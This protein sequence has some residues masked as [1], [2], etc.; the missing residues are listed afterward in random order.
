M[1]VK[2]YEKYKSTGEAPELITLTYPIKVEVANGKYEYCRYYFKDQITIPL[3]G[4]EQDSLPLKRDSV[5]LENV[6][7]YVVDGEWGHFLLSW[8]VL[9][10][11]GLSPEANLDRHKG[12]TFELS[13]EQQKTVSIDNEKTESGSPKTTQANVIRILKAFK[14]GQVSQKET[15]T[16]L[17]GLDWNSSKNED[18]F[19]I[20]NGIDK[21]QEDV[22]G[23]LGKVVD[24]GKA[25]IVENT[26]EVKVPVVGGRDYRDALPRTNKH[27]PLGPTEKKWRSYKANLLRT[28]DIIAEGKEEGDTTFTEEGLFDNPDE[29]DFESSLKTALAKAMANGCTQVEKLEQ[30]LP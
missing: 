14:A 4:N 6:V 21:D 20:I 18:G 3:R 16:S 26:K 22:R 5:R 17:E 29:I 11:L 23:L 10:S 30:I 15:E 12:R 24:R 1:G 2:Q 9:D 19:V 8:P 13:F 25:T 28:G 7:I 27:Y